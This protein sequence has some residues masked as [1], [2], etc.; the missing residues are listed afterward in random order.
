MVKVVV[1]AF[2]TILLYIIQYIILPHIIIIYPSDVERVYLTIILSTLLIVLP[3]MAFLADRF[4]YW[5]IFLLLYPIL[6]VLYHPANIYGIGYGMFS[7][8]LLTIVF[9]TIA[10]LLTEFLCW[11]LVKFLKTIIAKRS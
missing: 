8:G 9:L 11:G 7:I 4:R 1:P 10:V 2:T 6:V 3:T 5:L